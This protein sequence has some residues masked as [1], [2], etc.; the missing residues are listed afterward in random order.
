MKPPLKL[1]HTADVHLGA[2]FIGL[3]ERGGEQRRQLRET[4]Q[5]VADLAA[6]LPADAL[7]L[8]GDVFDSRTP[9]PESLAAFTQAMERIAQAR[10]P[11]FMI[12]GTHD[13]LD[14]NQT[15]PR[16]AKAHAGT[17][18]LLTPEHPTWSDPVKGLTVHGVSL[19]SGS[20][21]ER[22]LA[23]LR[24][25]AAAGWEV[26]LAHASLEQ[27]QVAAGEARFT[28]SEVAATGLDYLALGHWH[29]TRDCSQGG[30]TAWYPG[31]PEMIA[32]D[33]AQS[34]QVLVVTLEEGK[35][36]QV[37]PQ[38]VG[39]RTLVKLTL[40]VSQPTGARDQAL[41]QADPDAML[42]LTLTGML[43]AGEAFTVSDLRRDLASRF[44]HVRVKDQVVSELAAADLARFPETTALGRY[45]RLLQ[46]EMAR[47]QG[48]RLEDL[49]QALQLGLAM[50]EGREV[51]LW[52]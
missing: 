49:R 27:G 45:L 14:G 3:G 29:G 5:A 38:R 10:V 6:S 15:L 4:L 44:F 17:L 46:A 11:A 51:G 37:A 32:T 2:R 22:P 8:A 34:G 1:L 16:L 26:G 23:K 43:P 12:A 40:D 9:S 20:A 13:G 50:L 7:L 48:Q 30:V 18:T 31:P 39:K 52:S 24:R 35:R 47:A 36:P 42:E 28:P 21:P 41:A 19:L 33:E 25:T